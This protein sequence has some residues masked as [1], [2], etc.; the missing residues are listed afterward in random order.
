MFFNTHLSFFINEND[1]ILFFGE[2]YEFVDVAVYYNDGELE[3]MF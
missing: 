1:E 3:F 2:D